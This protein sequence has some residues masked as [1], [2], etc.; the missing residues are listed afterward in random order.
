[1][2]SAYNLLKTDLFPKAWYSGYEAKVDTFNS[3]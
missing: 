3:Q 1:M 2:V